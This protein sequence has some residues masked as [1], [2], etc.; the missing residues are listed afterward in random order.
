MEILC[1]AGGSAANCDSGAAWLPDFDMFGPGFGPV[2]QVS[3]FDL[4]DPNMVPG[5]HFG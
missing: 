5:E 4:G 2:V 1:F 3:M